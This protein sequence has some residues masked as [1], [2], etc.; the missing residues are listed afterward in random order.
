MCQCYELTYTWCFVATMHYASVIQSRFKHKHTLII[1]YIVAQVQKYIQ[2]TTYCSHTRSAGHH[3]GKAVNLQVL[4]YTST[5]R[6]SALGTIT[7]AD[8][9]HLFSHKQHETACVNA[10]KAHTSSQK[11]STSAARN[12]FRLESRSVW[13]GSSPMGGGDASADAIA[14]LAMA[15]TARPKPTG[16][17]LSHTNTHMSK[18]ANKNTKSKIINTQPIC[19]EQANTATFMI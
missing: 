11:S 3:F 6:I 14:A 18:Q 12:T 16:Y 2:S 19:D 15:A 13:L 9:K 10:G 1:T 17:D 8:H 5:L 7:V 4:R